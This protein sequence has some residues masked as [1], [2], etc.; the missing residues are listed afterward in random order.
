MA[1]LIVALPCQT[2]AAGNSGT[3]EETKIIRTASEMG[4]SITEDS[5][6]YGSP[7]FERV[8]APSKP[9]E[10]PGPSGQ[11]P[12][13]PAGNSMPLGQK[14]GYLVL[15]Y[16]AIC[17]GITDSGFI[18]WADSAAGFDEIS[19]ESLI[20]AKESRYA[21]RGAGED[22]L[23]NEE[24]FIQEMETLTGSKFNSGGNAEF[25]INGPASFAVK[26]RLMRE[27]QKSIY[28][29]SYAFYDDVTGNETVD[30]LL[31]KKKEGV[32]I[33]VIV[34][35]KMAY[36]FG[37]RLLKKMEAA[38]IEV[39]RYAETD[40]PHD[41][42]HIKM[43][44]VDGNYSVIGGMNYGDVYSHK[45][46]SLKWRDT[47]VLY[48]GPAVIESMKVF[49]KI[50]NPRTKGGLRLVTVPEN[51]DIGG[52][53]ARISVLYSNPPTLKPVILLGMLKGIYGATK[54]VNIENAYILAIPAL[55][56][57]IF[58]ARTRGVEVNILTNSKESIDSDGKSMAEAILN[59]VK[60][61]AAAG[62]NVYLKQGQ[63]LH[64]KFMTVDGVYCSVGSY[65]LH[66]R[67]ERYDTEMNIGIIDP[68]STARIDAAFAGD[69]AEANKLDPNAPRQGK[70]SWLDKIVEN[71]FFAQLLPGR[72]GLA[73]P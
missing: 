61:F 49:A 68:S 45:G 51:T 63:T 29:A 39:I 59:S 62:A 60:L 32:D 2:Y 42:L 66:P 23:L 28:I 8:P 19:K 13:P 33:K 53:Q 10:I 22:S 1:P 52:G 15:A 48:T 37:G 56:Q 67:S 44:L 57:A 24:G 34:D 3:D 14:W 72:R 6:V 50:W 69:I 7:A 58:D 11:Q 46:N 38:G 36:I 20:A 5:P 71:F 64:S 4:I 35:N 31:A 55:T 41:Y 9:Q 54:R 30:I 27:A 25:L 18:P 12:A 26:D 40:R 70:P 17:A 21:P 47:D 16:H 65:N 43:L 73:V